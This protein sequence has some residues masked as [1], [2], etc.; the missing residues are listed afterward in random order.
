MKR[1]WLG[2]ALAAFVAIAVAWAQVPPNGS[3]AN[4]WSQTLADATV[5]GNKFPIAASATGTT[6]IVTATMAADTAKT[7]FICGFVI[8]SVASAATAGNATVTGVQG[9]PLNFTM[10]DPTSQ[11]ILGVAFPACIS[12]TGKNVAI[13][14]TKPAGANTTIAAVTTWGYKQ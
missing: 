12:A 9:G 1:I 13:V 10:V 14:V 8:T 6:G 11:G 5:V 3:G 4:G 7:N 2:A